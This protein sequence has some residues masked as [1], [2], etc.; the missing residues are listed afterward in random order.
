M[1]DLIYNNHSYPEINEYQEIIRVLFAAVIYTH[2][3]SQL[4]DNPKS[5]LASGY[6]GEEFSLRDGLVLKLCSIQSCN[7]ADFTAQITTL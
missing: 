1:I 4:L 7:L 5:A 2:F 3:R 6:F